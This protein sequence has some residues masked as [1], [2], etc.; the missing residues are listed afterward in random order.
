MD[1]LKFDNRVEYYLPEID[2]FVCW[3]YTGKFYI[4]ESKL[5]KTK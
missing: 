3:E 5:S 2:V 1:I 4:G